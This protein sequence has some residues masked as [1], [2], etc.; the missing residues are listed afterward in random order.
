ML[1]VNIRKKKI[2]FFIEMFLLAQKVQTVQEN[3]KRCVYVIAVAFHQSNLGMSLP[4]PYP[5][6]ENTDKQYE[7]FL[8][9]SRAYY[10]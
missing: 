5:L 9:R 4:Y 7:M 2:V 3:T 1:A 10:F 6:I 8:I